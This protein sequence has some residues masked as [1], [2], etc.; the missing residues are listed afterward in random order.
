MMM[1]EHLLFCT[2]GPYPLPIVFIAAL[3]CMQM[4]VCNNSLDK[5]RMAATAKFPAVNTLKNEVTFLFIISEQSSQRNVT[6]I[7][8]F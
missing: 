4:S 7:D 3:G 5:I 8:L 1:Q 6:T 2:F